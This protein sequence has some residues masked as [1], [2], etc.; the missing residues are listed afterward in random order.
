VRADLHLF[1]PRRLPFVTASELNECGLACL[2]CVSEYFDG[3]FSLTDIRYLA[4]HSGRGETL[5]ELRDIAEHMGLAARGVR[6][7]LD[8]L[9]LLATPAILHWDMNHFV[10]LERVTRAGILIMDPAA[11]RLQ[12]S[13]SEVNQSFTGVALEIK[14]SA[15]WRRRSDKLP[16]A[17]ILDF[18]GPFATWRNDIGVIAALSLL[19]E[20][21][22]LVA[23]MQMRL[24]VDTALQSGDGRLVWLLGLGFCLVILLQASVSIVRAWAIAV[25]STRVG[26]ELKDRFVRSLHRK[27]AR[28]FTTHHS[29]DI[30]SRSHSVDMIQH[31]VTAQLLQA[32]MDLLMSIAIV[33]VIFI[34]VPILALVVSAFGLINLAATG[35][36]RH[37]AMEVSRRSLRVEA[38]ADSLFL[39]NARAARAIK[40]F[41]KEGA[42]TS[43]WRNKFVE[44]INLWLADERLV[45]FSTQAAQLTT[46]LCNVALISIGAYL[47]LT[48]SITLGTMLMVF[49]F[50]TFLMERIDN[51]MNYAME[52]RRV[53]THAERIH[54][55]ISD[56]ESTEPSTLRPF[57][58]GP[59][60][61]VS[62]RMRDVWFR[63]G[64]ASPWL[65]KGVNL[66]IE[67]GESVAIVGPSGS[68]KTT[69][70]HLLVGLLEPTQGEILI[71][72]RNLRT[73]NS[74]D[75]A[76]VVGAVMQDDMLFQGT[77]ADN[78]SFFDAPVD[79]AR[80]VEVARR[81][82]IARECEAM[83]MRYYS[84]LA[85]AATD[86]SG[87]QKQRLFIARALYH[88]PRILFLD[89]A[90]SHLD[91]E[92]EALVNRA[93]TAMEITRVLVAHRQNT[94][95]MADRVLE[96]DPKSGLIVERSPEIGAEPPF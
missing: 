19:L 59:D 46:G 42:R 16:R 5:L 82:N 44:L 41:G 47:V 60:Q 43:V 22:V 2:A 73:I 94:I 24:S 52:L 56:S 67:P 96:V 21:L 15:H 64:D 31:I 95:A 76:K 85:E 69:L 78:I 79:M 26:Y 51:C 11:G 7:G 35:G 1:G 83:P 93:I 40:L 9:A 63:Y 8:A 92:S 17:S 45:L 37:A 86:I 74:S 65:L 3:S 84:L 50:S 18:V 70:M 25:F 23:P 91:A 12:I 75:Y 87:G 38:V 90:T 77:V 6:V 72:D 29:A 66:T 62:L 34:S 28:F 36:L 33:V 4:A 88:A 80:V 61:G 68:G 32:L 10:V 54:E 20:I 81:A 71:N 89:E 57:I 55:I 49:V 48:K 53:Q 39:E 27:S 13:W 58:V 14:T 30:L